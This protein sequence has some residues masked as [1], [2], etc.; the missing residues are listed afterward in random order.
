MK[1]FIIGI[2]LSFVLAVPTVAQ[3]KVFC[4]IVGVSKSLFGLRSDVTISVDFGQ[5]STWRDANKQF[6]VDENGEVIVF[7][8]MVDA[9]NYLGSLG[10]E[11]EQAYAIGTDGTYTYHYLMSAD[12]SSD[13]VT[14]LKTISMYEEDNTPKEPLSSKSPINPDDK[15]ICSGDDGTNL[16]IGARNAYYL[17]VSA[18]EQILLGQ[19][20]TAVEKTLRS[21]YSTLS[22]LRAGESGRID[23]NGV[24]YKVK[25]VTYEDTGALVFTDVDGSYM[26]TPESLKQYLTE[27]RAF[28]SSE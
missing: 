19:D 14:S 28:S 26:L 22:V 18:Y 21:L 23:A 15:I 25:L 2:I 17:R 8:S 3:N 9:L 6:L 12:A 7:N 24:A 13:A 10:W 5:L 20:W 27:G 11:F 16:A 4:E 1:K